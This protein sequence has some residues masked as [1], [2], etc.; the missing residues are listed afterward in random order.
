MATNPVKIVESSPPSENSSF[1][2]EHLLADIRGFEDELQKLEHADDVRSVAMRKV[3]VNLLEHRRRL[4]EAV[5]NGH[6]ED[7]LKYS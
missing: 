4:L 5:R 7:W 3:Y 1:N 2:E 6:P